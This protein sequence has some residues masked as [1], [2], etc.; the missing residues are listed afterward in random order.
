MMNSSSSIKILV[1]D[2]EP[3]I[4]RSLLEY[5]DDLD[6]DVA[7]ADSGE[8]AL[9]LITENHY[10]LGII[11][12]RLPGINGD[13][14]IK[15]AHQIN[16]EMQFIIHTGSIGYKL[17][18]DLLNIGMKP[19]NVLLKPLADLSQIANTIQKLFFT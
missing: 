5:L 9:K 10:N 3:S 7:S 16:P 12:L 11:D 15:H 14:L 19:E 2:D 8:E 17:S 6:Y 4:R 18:Q 13:V 1:V